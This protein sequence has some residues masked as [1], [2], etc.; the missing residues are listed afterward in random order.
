MV[1]RMLMREQTQ[2]CRQVFVTQSK[3][4]AA[5]VQDYFYK[6]KETM[7]TAAMSIDDIRRIAATKPS[8][9]KEEEDLMNLNEDEDTRVDLPARY[10]ELE[11]AHFPLFVTFNQVSDG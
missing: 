7:E 6:V 2:K 5:R 3:I 1:I 10:S 11:D 9:V 8:L 4:L